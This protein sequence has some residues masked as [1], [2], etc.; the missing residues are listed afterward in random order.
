MRTALLLVA[1]PLALLLPR[2]AQAATINV[3]TAD[4][5]AKIEGAKPGDEVVIAPG[6]Y[7]FRVFL[8]QQA[9]PQ[10]PI[11][12]RALDPKNPPVWD[13]GST[14]VEDAPGS[15]TAGDRGRGCWQLS[16]A[17][18][19]HISGIVFTNCRNA[20]KNSAGIRYY[21]GTKD[22]I[23]SDAVF[24]T[25]D[26]GMTGG[27]Q[28]SE[29]TVLHSEFDRNGNLT[30][31]APT[32][33]V[34][35]YG[36]TFTMRYSYLHDPVQ[37]QN[38]HIRAKDGVIEYNWIARGKSYE[39][40]LMTDDDDPG[41][42]PYAQ[43]L[44][45]RG[46]VIV[47]GAPQNTS[48]IIA[49]Y[50]DSGAVQ[51][52]LALR[53]VD[54]TFVVALPNSNVVHLSNADGTTMTAELSNNLFSSGKPVLIEDTGKG[55]A[56]GTNNWF[57]TGTPVGALT[58]S[59]FGS[60]PFKNAGGMDFT[61]APGSNAIGAAGASV[62]GLPDREYFQNETV[63]R[64]YRVRATAKDIGAFE[65]TTTGAGIGPYDT[66]P[67]QTDGGV[68][69]TDGGWTPGDEAGLAPDA[70]GYGDPGFAG[71][72]AGCGCRQAPGGSPAGGVLVGLGALV[73]VLRRRR[74]ATASS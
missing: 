64:M 35:I 7:T 49:V 3:T 72:S 52:T 14:L 60:A 63:A 44:L 27:T 46:N 47:Q 45:L 28:G 48:Q 54:N 74:R 38:F 55:T 21:N 20:G 50:N 70:G 62:A 17:T 59:V 12:I 37:A 1:V 43:K 13:F 40:D 4:T 57:P 58:A 25:N 36:G 15:Y 31:G 29:M 9:T 6:K 53:A 32:H 8:T 5:Y 67:P 41:T 33:N 22:I 34:Y 11:V 26:D 10:Q 2:A 51:L 24:R 16:G 30:A 42:G 61:L 23:V 56:S 69:V 39:G 68:P 66:P 19:I 18:S 65:S 71:P 73:G